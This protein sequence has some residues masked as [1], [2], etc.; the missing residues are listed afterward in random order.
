MAADPARCSQPW[1][2]AREAP[3]VLTPTGGGRDAPGTRP[4]QLCS[5]HPM[6]SRPGATSRPLGDRPRRPGTVRLHGGRPRGP[7]AHPN[8]R[9]PRIPWG[10]ALFVTD[11]EGL[12]DPARWV[13]TFQSAFPQATWVALGLTRIPDDSSA[14]AAQGLDLELEDV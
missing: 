3:F 6:A 12:D 1:P 14:W 7:S 5:G 13:K 10:N 8:S 2:S 9:Q 11:D 4:V